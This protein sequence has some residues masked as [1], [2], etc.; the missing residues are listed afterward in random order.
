MSHSTLLFLKELLS[1]KKKFNNRPELE[2]WQREQLLSHLED[3][4]EKSPFYKKYYENYDT[5]YLK[6]LPLINKQIMMDN[7]DELNTKGISKDEALEL[8]FKSEESR[9][10]SPTIDNVTVGLSSGTSGNRGLFLVSKEEQMKWAALVIKKLLPK[11]WIQKQTI[12]FFLR[13]NSNLYTTINK[14]F[15]KFKFF[16]LLEDLDVNM[17][18]LNKLNP[19]ILVGPPSMLRFIAENQNEGKININPKK[20]I[21]VAEVLEDIDKKYISRTFNQII[22]QVY[23]CTEGF[24]GY[25]CKYG[26][27]HLNEDMV[28]F[29]RKYLDYERF[30]PIISDFC[31]KTQPIIKYELNDILVEN[32]GPCKCGSLFT[33]IDRIEGRSDDIF[34]VKAEDGKEI[35]IFPDFIRRAIISASNNIEEYRAIQEDEK[36]I[37]IELKGKISKSIEQKVKDNI[38]NLLDS[39]SV[40]NIHFKEYN[41]KPSDTKLRRIQRKLKK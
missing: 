27:L 31:R 7:F 5:Y 12:G 25:T 13:A 34:Y 18:K 30:I 17:E 35:T 3:I 15:I 10:F 2:H 39:S 9:D 20:I 36:T 14:G 28:L 21:S 37:T 41:I 26:H 11:P 33:R 1:K 22:H 16:D 24:L 19:T 32:K 6:K 38:Y 40:V 4:K 23:Q 8:A 29:E